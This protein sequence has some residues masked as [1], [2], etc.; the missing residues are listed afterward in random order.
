MVDSKTLGKLIAEE[1][2][3]L[4]II[5]NEWDPIGD[6]PEDEYDSFRDPII[7][8]LH[9]GK[10]EK[11]IAEFLSRHLEGYVGL[12][13]FPTESQEVAKKILCWWNKRNK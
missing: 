13:S 9:K 4:R 3:E 12:Q 10:T 11:D 7:S 1:Q 2:K 8:M 5:L 6:V